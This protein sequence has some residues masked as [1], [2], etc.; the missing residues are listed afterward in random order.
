M[1]LV[2]QMHIDISKSKFHPLSYCDKT[3]TGKIFCVYMHM[4]K[5]NKML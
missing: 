5:Y 1:I 4:S 2:S 3:S